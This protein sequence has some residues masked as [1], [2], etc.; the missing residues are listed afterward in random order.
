LGGLAS[1]VMLF[2]KAISA[3]LVSRL[4]QAALVKKAYRIQHYDFDNTRY[5]KKSK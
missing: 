4:L 1:I 2:G 5:E 3:S